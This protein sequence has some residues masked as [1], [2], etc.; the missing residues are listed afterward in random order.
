M[1]AGLYPIFLRELAEGGIQDI[2]TW[3]YDLSVPYSHAGWR[4]R[5]RASQGVGASLSATQVAAF[6]AA[7]AS[8]LA[9]EFPAEPLH[10]PH[11]VW[12]AHGRQ[13]T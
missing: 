4:G 11:R 13:P 2:E 12:V 1:A 8:L 9:Q 10:V 3:S 7:L 5:I 6:D